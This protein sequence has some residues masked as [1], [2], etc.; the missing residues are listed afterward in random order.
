MG[1]T[2]PYTIRF[3]HTAHN[4]RIHGQRGEIT[5]RDHVL[6]KRAAHGRPGIFMT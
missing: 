2:R 5:P 3:L 1:P 4:G 6:S